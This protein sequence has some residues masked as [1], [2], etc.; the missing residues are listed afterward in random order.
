[1]MVG[2]SR[3]IVEDCFAISLHFHLSPS[4]YI[5]LLMWFR[6][7]FEFPFAKMEI[8]LCF[9]PLP[10]KVSLFVWDTTGRKGPWAYEDNNLVP[11][12]QM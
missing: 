2:P 9:S 4:Y 6:L 3:V 5:E 7:R 8:T 12:Q 1:M 11:D 10:D